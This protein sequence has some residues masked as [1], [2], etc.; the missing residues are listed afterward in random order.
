MRHKPNPHPPPNPHPNPR[1]NPRPSPF[2][3]R[4][5]PFAPSPLTVQV[6]LHKV[7]ERVASLEN[8][9][10]VTRSDHAALVARVDAGERA[11]VAERERLT[12]EMTAAAAVRAKVATSL[13]EHADKLTEQGGGLKTLGDGIARI[14]KDLAGHAA[15]HQ[16]HKRS[17]K[18]QRR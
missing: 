1:P 17:T 3:L 15:Q 13:E 5:S 10:D 11:A 14:D 8:R 4:P 2:A 6:M 18:V 7:N 16:E 9:V 12:A